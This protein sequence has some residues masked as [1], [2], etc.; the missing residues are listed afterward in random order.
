MLLGHRRGFERVG[1][2]GTGVEESCGSDLGM[3]GFSLFYFSTG[4]SP[5]SGMPNFR[6]RAAEQFTVRRPFRGI[7]NCQRQ[8]D[9]RVGRNA[10]EYSLPF[11][12]CEWEYS[13][14]V[15][16]SLAHGKRNDN[17]VRPSVHHGKLCFPV[18]QS[19]HHG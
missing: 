18:F 11:F 2:G 12:F 6:A 1:G 3:E 19:L 16:S 14:P 13:L 10:R 9:F 17:P 8:K 4:P 5:F 15:S 7:L